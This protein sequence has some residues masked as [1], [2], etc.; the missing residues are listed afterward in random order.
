MLN[1]LQSAAIEA[2]YARH[3]SVRQLW[4]IWEGHRLRVLVTLE[5]THDDNDTSPAWVAHCHAWADE[6]QLCT[7]L[8][9]QLELIDEPM[10]E[11]AGSGGEGANLARLSWRDPTSAS[12][13]TE[14]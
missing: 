2:W 8:P 14:V 7:N 13:Q 6:L 12:S 5:P 11:G 3:A 9:V 10:L 1:D 4:A